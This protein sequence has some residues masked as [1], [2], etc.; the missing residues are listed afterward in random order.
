MPFRSSHILILQDLFDY[1]RNFLFVPTSV[2][3]WRSP[4]PAIWAD[5]PT[6]DPATPRSSCGPDPKAAASG[7]GRQLA[8]GEV[9][10]E[11]RQAV[12]STVGGTVAVI[13]LC[14]QVKSHLQPS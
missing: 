9:A 7:I 6:C 11:V 5:S 13:S 10:D 1:L 2:F 12:G 14:C 3:M 8:A 4:F